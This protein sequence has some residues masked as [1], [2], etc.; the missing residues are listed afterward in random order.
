[1]AALCVKEMPLS[2]ADY[3]A[4]AGDTNRFRDEPDGVT[5]LCFGLFGEIG[6]L[7]AALK[8]V[9][10]DK[11]LESETHFAAEEIGDA[12][13]YLV[14]LAHHGGVEP[15][16]LAAACILGLRRR[17]N[18]A[19]IRPEG[20]VSFEEIDSLA[21]LHR[22]KFEG[23][24]ENL[25]RELAAAAGALTASSQQNFKSWTPEKVADTLGGLMAQLALVARCFQF[26]LAAAAR[27]NLNKIKDRWPGD[28]P[29]FCRLF[30][31]SGCEEHERLP[32]QFE[33]EFITRKVGNRTVV[34]QQLNG[35][36]IGDPLTDNSHVPDGYSYHDV[37]HLSYVAHLG[38]SPVIRALLKLKR[39]SRSQVDE[40]E[41][42]ARAI[43]IEEGIA[44]WIFNHAH[45]RGDFEGVQIGK[46]EFGL[47]KQ[48]RA[49]VQGYEV[50]QCPWWQ[51][52]LAIL[53][54][55]E[56]FRELR[57]HKRG[58]VSVDMVKRTLTFR[59]TSEPRVAE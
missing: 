48:V 40:N 22:V 23:Q 53:R 19:E 17:L 8:K 21:E 35:V 15:D 50:H 34:V 51:W 27:E 45:A 58:I 41:D 59:P 57:E 31:A 10:R 1:M 37:F 55:F 30:D 32:R 5:Q 29:E 33:I 49:M 6:S 16:L 20:G 18:E 26:G 43:I 28:N 44:T 46:L 54:G 42:G 38:W 3:F 36:N 12:L 11:L 56:V 13:W 39:K 14:S 4:K 47:L 7:L 52:E 9:S 2:V 25:L 24:R